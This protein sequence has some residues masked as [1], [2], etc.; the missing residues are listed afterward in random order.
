MSTFLEGRCDWAMMTSAGWMAETVPVPL[1]PRR[2]LALHEIGESQH[3]ILNPFTDSQ[4]LELAAVA[5]AG[6]GTRVLDLA[7]GK[8]EMLCRWAQEFGS[9]GIGV[10]ISEV[11]LA[12]ARHR[13]E[14][15]GVRDRVGF[16]RG[17]ASKYEAEPASFDLAAC[18]GASWIGSGP[19]AGGP[20]PH[21]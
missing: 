14:Q 20:D 8:G 12:A 1:D 5:R 10:D 6:A 9:S 18:I 19:G 11:F 21:R 3:R 17:N 13:A 2:I 4:L 15:L 16:H 7:C